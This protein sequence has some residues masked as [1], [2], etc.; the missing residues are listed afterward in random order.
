[1]GINAWFTD[2]RISFMAIMIVVL[3][4]GFKL[5]AGQMMGVYRVQLDLV[6]GPLTHQKTRKAGLS[7]VLV[8]SFSSFRFDSDIGK[9]S[10][11]VVQER[12]NYNSSLHVTIKPPSFC[13]IFP[14]PKQK[15]C[16]FRSPTSLHCYE[17]SFWRCHIN[18]FVA[19][20]KH[21]LRL[22]LC[23]LRDLSKLAFT[24]MLGLACDPWRFMLILKKPSFSLDTVDG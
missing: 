24:S 11:V 21:C 9:S 7:F 16:L 22:P 2:S 3:Q 18:C 10:Q 20:F 4:L 13:R 15:V 6:M 17:S 14:S 23:L 8:T 12:V 19:E 5:N 1:M